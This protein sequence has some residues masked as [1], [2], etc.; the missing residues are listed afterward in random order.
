MICDRCGGELI[1]VEI[2]ETRFIDMRGDGNLLKRTVAIR[3][4]AIT[5]RKEVRDPELRR[6]IMSA[7]GLE[8]EWT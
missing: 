8:P 1:D 2:E 4:S 7:S 6:T 5:C 3:H